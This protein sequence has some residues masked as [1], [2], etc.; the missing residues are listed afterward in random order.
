MRSINSPLYSFFFPLA[1][2]HR[3][4]TSCDA[5]KATLVVLA[6][7]SVAGLAIFSP[8]ILT[9]RT[10]SNPGIQ[11]ATVSSCVDRYNSLLKDAK[12][13]LVKG[14]RATTV[15]LLEQ[16]ERLIPDCPALRDAA[17]PNAILLSL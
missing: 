8:R 10:A 15:D 2:R 16:A 17:S 3:D 6:L 4:C 11:P 13:A 12:G 5:M 7:V 1:A 14:D 9:A